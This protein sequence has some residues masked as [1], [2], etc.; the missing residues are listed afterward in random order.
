M[1]TQLSYTIN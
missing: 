1:W